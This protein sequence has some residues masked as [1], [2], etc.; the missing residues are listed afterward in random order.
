MSATEVRLNIV[1]AN[2]DIPAEADKTSLVA[3]IGTALSNKSGVAQSET[4]SDV[5][6]GSS[7]VVANDMTAY[8]VAIAAA[9][10]MSVHRRA[11]QSDVNYA[12]S[13]LNGASETFL[14]AR[15]TGTWPGQHN[16]I[17]SDSITINF[18]EERTAGTI[19]DSV[20]YRFLPDTDFTRGTNAHIDLSPSDD[21][22]RTIQFRH[23]ADVKDASAVY[24]LIIPR[25]P[26]FNIN[27]ASLPITLTRIGSTNRF[28]VSTGSVITEAQRYFEF[29]DDG[30]TSWKPIVFRGGGAQA[31]YDE[32]PGAG[33]TPKPT[34]SQEIT[35]EGE[36]ATILVR[37][38]AH[39][40][41]TNNTSGAFRP[42]A[43][44]R[45][46]RLGEGFG[47]S[48]RRTVNVPPLPTPSAPALP[49]LGSRWIN[50]YT[51]ELAVG[52]SPAAEW[53]WGTTGNWTTGNGSPVE[54][55]VH[56]TNQQRLQ[57]RNRGDSGLDPGPITD[58]YI[59]SR[60]ATQANGLQRVN[61]V[62][63]RR[64][65]KSVENQFSLLPTGG[66]NEFRVSLPNTLP[67]NTGPDS[68]PVNGGEALWAFL[69]Y[70]EDPYGIVGWKPLVFRVRNNVAS[71]VQPGP[72]RDEYP[73]G[74]GITDNVATGSRRSDVIVLSEGVSSIRVRI[75]PHDGATNHPLTNANLAVPP[76]VTRP[77]STVPLH[78]LTPNNSTVGLGY[79]GPHFRGSEAQT[80]TV[81]AN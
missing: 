79:R 3:A 77:G 34:V 64:D 65:L 56:L 28:T 70:T 12:V 72:G 15:Q 73:R 74:G 17:L 43:A 16:A 59:P 41:G 54:F 32:W 1:E 33:G 57:I 44:F 42:G 71:D 69:E 51:E 37:V 48:V 30:G 80:I 31:D 29:S 19:G 21:F 45:L 7:W 61:N 13:S 27:T 18:Y 78:N 24:E 81:T 11:S 58:V 66:A 46:W 5:L 50:W 60:D 63:L 23:R 6:I 22:A 76:N 39:Q 4:G 2:T 62:W 47:G 9:V 36:P 8:N 20:E 14:A 53:R 40:G 35:I 25:R 55:T 49:D 38:G 52:I 10:G 75:G 26:E 68:G 67:A